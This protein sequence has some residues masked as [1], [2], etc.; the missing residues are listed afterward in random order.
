MI[1]KVNAL[2]LSET[3]ILLKSSYFL[4]IMRIVLLN[5]P[6]SIPTVMPYSLAMMNAVLKSEI[7]EDISAV[8]LNAWYHHKKFNDFITKNCQK[9]V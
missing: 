9:L 7:D 4:Q 6:V 1:F 5:L 3:I 8:D 2:L